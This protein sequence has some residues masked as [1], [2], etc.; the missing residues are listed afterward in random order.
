MSAAARVGAMYRRYFYLH[1]RSLPRTFEI[2]FWP[3]MELLVWGYVAVYIKKLGGDPMESVAFGLINALIFWDILYR[4]QQGVSVS[5]V[6]DIWTQNIVNLL[7]APLRLREWV[8]ATF[9][10]GTTKTALITL[11]LAV[12]SALMY[13][14]HLVDAMQLA[15]VPL[16]F[17]LLLFGWA[18]GIFTAGLILRWGHAAEALIW[19]IP[20]LVQPLSAIFYP[21]ETLPGPLQAVAR[22]LPSTYVFEG[23]RSVLRGDGLPA[24]GM[25]VSFLLNIGY[26]VLAGVFFRWMYDLS[27]RS[28]RLGRL[29]MD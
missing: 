12:M 25:A 29:G 2:V 19:G 27:R 6:E 3:V 28:G 20:F 22:C 17:N 9:L 4:S 15:L 1:K 18:L 8:L 23:M 24:G 5:F 13:H 21:L 16:V 26:F 11:I 10:Y 7:V 14:Y